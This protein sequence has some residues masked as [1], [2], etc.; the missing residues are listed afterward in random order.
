VAG[1]GRD[2]SNKSDLIAAL[3]QEAGIQEIIEAMITALT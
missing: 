3:A 1:V 2:T